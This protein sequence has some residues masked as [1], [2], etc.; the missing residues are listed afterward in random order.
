MAYATIKYGSSGSDVAALQKKLNENGYDLQ[1]DG[2]F[3]SATRSAVK[4]Y[5]KQQGL[6]VDG[7]V[8]SATWGSLLHSDRTDGAGSTGKEVLAGVSDET[9]DLLAALEKGYTPSDEVAAARALRDSLA[10]ARPE[11]PASSFDEELQQL[12]DRMISRPGFSYDPESDGAY[13]QQA[14]LYSSGGRRAM[15]DTLGQ[16]AAL[17]GGYGSS[18]AQTAAQQSYNAYMQQ[19][20]ALIPELEQQALQRHQAQGQAL[21][22]KYEAALDARQQEKA[23]WEAVYDAWLAEYERS[24][25]AYEDEYQRDYAHYKLLLDYFA[26]KAKQ[27]QKAS[28][29]RKV[30]SG[31]VSAAAGE[32]GA[33]SSTAAG[34]LERAV[35]NYLKAGNSEAA[36]ALTEQYAPRMTAAQKKRFDQL[37]KKYGAAM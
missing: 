21:Q 28:D 15:A 20:A 23:A 7:I 9:S 32:K 13:Q 4:D 25:E 27:E 3:G 37:L 8:G 14:R 5:Q 24:D 12:Y 11:E 29:G 30:N 18:Y 2:R 34:S 26:D 35:G 17:T 16:A 33:L 19:L 31:T 22:D 10:A 1:V 6:T 36:L